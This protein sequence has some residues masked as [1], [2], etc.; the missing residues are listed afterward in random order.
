MA[1]R[2]LRILFCKLDELLESTVDGRADIGHVLVELDGGNSTLAD[3]L[4]GEFELLV[5]ILICT[6]STESVETELL[7]GVPLPTHG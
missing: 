4:W 5:N 2:P 1:Q 3:T 6:T 7:V